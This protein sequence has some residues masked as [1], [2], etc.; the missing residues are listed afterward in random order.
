MLERRHVQFGTK[1]RRRKGA[2]RGRYDPMET[3]KATSNVFMYEI[4]HSEDAIGQ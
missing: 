2:D 1:P 4:V 3:V